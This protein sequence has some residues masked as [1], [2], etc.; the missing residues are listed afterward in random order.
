MMV[1]EAENLSSTMPPMQNLT[2]MHWGCM[3]WCKCWDMMSLIVVLSF[4]MLP[5]TWIV[6]IALTI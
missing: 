1:C 5:N 4:L 3:S 6:L 2:L